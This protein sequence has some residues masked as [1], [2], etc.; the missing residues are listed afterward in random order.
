M[1]DQPTMHAVFVRGND[2]PVATFADA[3]QA[4]RYRR[5]NHGDDAVVVP[6]EG[7]NLKAAADAAAEAL[8]D[9]ATAATV[10]EPG[11]TAD[12][13]ATLRGEIRSELVE[14]RRRARITKEVEAELDAEE[15]DVKRSET[16]APTSAAPARAE[17]P[18]A[19]R[20]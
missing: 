7:S 3:D 18:S 1:A 20:G 15:R 11:S 9:P 6:V 16:P 13:D 17:T 19:R 4:A 14:Q 5:D 12:P 2:Q 10:A 8:P